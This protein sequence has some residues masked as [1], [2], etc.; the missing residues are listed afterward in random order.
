MSKTDLTNQRQ[1]FVEEYVRT[2]WRSSGSNTEGLIQ[3][4][5]HNFCATW[6]VKLRRQYSD[7]I[8]EELHRNFAELAAC[9]LNILTNLAENAESES[10]RLK[11]TRDLLDREQDSGQLARD[12]IV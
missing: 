12:E 4:H 2:L 3:R 6:P 1:V 8:T 7:E 9:V 5:T 10:V 11:T